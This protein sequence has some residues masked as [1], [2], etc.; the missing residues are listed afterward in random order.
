[1]MRAPASR[2]ISCIAGTNSVLKEGSGTSQVS[3][4]DSGLHTQLQHGPGWLKLF[5]FAAV[6]G[7]VH[8]LVLEDEQ[9]G[10]RFASE[11]NH[12]LV[13][14]FDPTAHNFAIVELNGNR[15]LLLA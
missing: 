5:P 7:D 8:D 10:A 3:L 14:V 13:V 9:I 15:L 2:A 4:S 12:I 6:F 11:A 1:M